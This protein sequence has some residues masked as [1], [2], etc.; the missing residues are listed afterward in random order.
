M[1]ISIGLV[2]LMPRVYYSDPELTVGWK[3]RWHFSVLAPAMTLAA[4][5]VLVDSPIK[6]AIKDPRP[7]CTLDRTSAQYPGSGCE[8]FGMPSTESFAAWGASGAGL[9]IFLV[10]AYKY[11]NGRLND[12]AFVGDVGVPITLSI[13]TSVLR[14]VAPGGL[15]A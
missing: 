9:S 15:S 1:A 14:G 6:N 12:L 4:L 8:S 3:G 7:G 13:V 2:G 11:S 10:D 5:T